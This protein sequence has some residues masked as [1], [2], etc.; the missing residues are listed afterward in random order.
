MNTRITVSPRYNEISQFI[1]SIP[2]IFHSQGITIYKARN[3]IK[4]F[5]VNGV[6]L[7]VKKYQKP[8]IINQIAYGIFRQSKAKR[9]YL[10]A[11]RL[12][13]TGIAT[14]EPIAYIEQRY[15]WLLIN[16]YFV[17]IFED[18]PHILRELHDYTVKG[19]EPL[20]K[21]FASYTANMHSK[22]IYPV[23]YSPGNVLFDQQEDTFHFTLLDI[24]RMRFEPVNQ[25]MAACGFRRLHVKPEVLIA[26]ATEYAKLRGYCIHSFVEQTQYY[27]T[28]FWK[29]H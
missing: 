17:S 8:H 13:E 29:K 3:E 21:A 28:K 23:D 6:Q 12:L 22:D 14:P 2:Q 1:H 5:E 11:H 25:E 20:L 26:I 19:N 10:Y 7:T 15:G 4:K 18:Y 24:N 9:A 27:H 16:A